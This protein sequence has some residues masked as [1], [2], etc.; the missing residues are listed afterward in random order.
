MKKD[1]HDPDKHNGVITHWEPD[2]L[3]CEV[4][5]IMNKTSRGNETPVELFEILKDD[6][7]KVLHSI[8]K[9]IW[10]TQQWAQDWKRSVFIL[11]PKKDNAKECSNH[12]TITLISHTRKVMPQ[13]LQDRLQKHVNHE[14]QMFKL[15]LEKGE[16]SKIK[17]ST[18]TG[19]SKKQESSRKTWHLLYWLCQSLWLCGS[20]QTVENS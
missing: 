9:Q 11:I 14:L 2:I 18:P 4:S 3:E 8:C 16:E 15:D 17:L 7:I 6:A 1:L 13:I 10:K 5:I 19:S 20:Q 12:C